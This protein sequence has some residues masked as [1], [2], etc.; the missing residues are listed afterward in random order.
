MN[1]AAAIRK[2]KEPTSFVLAE[3]LMSIA[4]IY[5]TNGR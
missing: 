3:T 1:K 5:S 2:E 4:G